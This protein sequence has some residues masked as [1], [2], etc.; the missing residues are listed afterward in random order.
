MNCYINKLIMLIV[1]CA[2]LNCH[3]EKYSGGNGTKTSPFQ[4]SNLKDLR[5]LSESPK[6]WSNKH[7]VVTS[8]IDASTTKK[9]NIGNHDND[10]ETPVVPMG[11]SPIGNQKTQSFTGSFDGDGHTIKNLY[12]NRP[13]QT[14]TGLFGYLG[15]KARSKTYIKNLKLQN[16]EING[17]ITGSIAG[18]AMKTNIDNCSVTG[19]VY[20]IIETGGL[21]GFSE[22][23][24]VKN[25]SINMIV[26]CLEGDAGGCIGFAKSSKLTNCKVNGFVSTQTRV[27]SSYMAADLIACRDQKTTTQKCN[28]KARVFNYSQHEVATTE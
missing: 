17:I 14:L 4:I 18:C 22:Q 10:C 11:F 27:L 5:T 24:N 26:K 3:T 12:I 28:S 1:L 25:S 9:W 19:K 2:S 20:G 21:L 16:C 15:N 7:F 8:D 23:T 6:D 13:K